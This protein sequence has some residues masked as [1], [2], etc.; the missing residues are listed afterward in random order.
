M[1]NSHL[2]SRAKDLYKDTPFDVIESEDGIHRICK[3]IHKCD[4]RS[5]KS[6]RGSFRK[7]QENK[8][9]N[10]FQ[11]SL[12]NTNLYVNSKGVENGVIVIHKMAQMDF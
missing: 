7:I 10:P 9:G 11:K 8:E 5:V 6:L 12:L 4:A 2:Y 1:L 3:A